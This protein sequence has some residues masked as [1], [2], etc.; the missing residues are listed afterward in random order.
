MYS[1]FFYQSQK[2][3]S[4]GNLDLENNIIKSSSN[5]V[6]NTNYNASCRNLVFIYVIGIFERG[7]ICDLDSFLTIQ[8]LPFPL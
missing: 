7:V 1:I 5:K 8:I 2:L 3:I 6:Q 4:G